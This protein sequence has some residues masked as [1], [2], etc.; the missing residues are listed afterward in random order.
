MPHRNIFF[1]SSSVNAHGI[2]EI[3]A[4][5]Y[6]HNNTATFDTFYFG[7][8]VYLNYRAAHDW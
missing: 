7:K 4:E 8:C 5:Q 6:I 1:R 2:I 3:S